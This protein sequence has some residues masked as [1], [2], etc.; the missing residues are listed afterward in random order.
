MMLEADQLVFAY[1]RGAAR[2]LDG[3]CWKQP[4][5]TFTFLVGPNGSGKTTALKLLAG[6]RGGGWMTGEVRLNGRD[7]RHYSHRERAALIGVVP[8][9]LPPVLDFTVR[10]MVELGLEA[11]RSGWRRGSGRSEIESALNLLE[12]SDLAF[13]PCNRLSGGERQRVAVAAALVRRPRFLLLD[14]PTSALDP[15]HAL[16][17]VRVLR[18]VSGTPGCLMVT[19]DLNLALRYADTVALMAGGRVAAF[20]PPAQVLTAER[21]RE[22]YHCGAEFAEFPSGGNAVRFIE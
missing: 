8:Q 7:I 11:G 19:H 15:E 3:F 21:V 17:L 4:A 2:V 22:V 12:L 16:R 9:M 5:G 18:G 13:R 14:E 10:D 1:R 20:G 6:W